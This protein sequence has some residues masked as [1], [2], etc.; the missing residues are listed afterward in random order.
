MG[1]LGNGDCP[2]P[3]RIEAL[4][5]GEGDAADAAHLE[6][7][8]RCRETAKELERLSAILR[9]ARREIEPPPLEKEM[10]IFEAFRDEHAAPAGGKGGRQERRYRWMGPAAAVAAAMI[11]ALSLSTWWKDSAGEGGVVVAAREEPPR[12]GAERPAEA[13][14]TVNAKREASSD[15]SARPSSYA[16]VAGDVTG[17]GRIDI[18]DAFRLALAMKG[19]GK[20]DPAWDADGDGRV[21]TADVERLARL[22]VN[23]GGG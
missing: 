20:T 21:D 12:S 22:A 9:K 23:L 14:R 8:D 17:D 11:I 13:S 15:V 7:C 5:T 16:R 19:G 4:R 2:S 18:L 1:T 10:A 3:E 6:K